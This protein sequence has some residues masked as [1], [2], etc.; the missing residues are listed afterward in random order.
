MS[1]R[2]ME[3]GGKELGR[4]NGKGDYNRDRAACL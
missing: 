2:R 1:M 4:D 3:L